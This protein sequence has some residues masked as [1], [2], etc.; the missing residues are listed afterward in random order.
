MPHWPWPTPT[1]QVRYAGRIHEQPSHGLAHCA[2]SPD[3]FFALGDVLLDWAVNDPAQAAPLLAKA[4]TA[5][6]RCLTET[7]G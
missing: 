6:L 3:V 4:E 2:E 1:G 7:P 5:W